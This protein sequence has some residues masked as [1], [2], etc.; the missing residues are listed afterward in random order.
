MGKAPSTVKISKTDFVL[1]ALTLALGLFLSVSFFYGPSMINGADNYIYTDSAHDLLSGNFNAMSGIL[2]ER[3]LLAGGIAFFY[4]LFGYSPASAAAFGVLCFLLTIVLIYLIGRK[5]YS[6]KAG[7]LAAFL[8][9]FLPL[10]VIESS[11]VGDDVPM[12][13]FATLSVFSAVK[14]SLGNSRHS[15]KYFAIAGF[16]SLASFLVSSESVIIM[17]VVL[18]VFLAYLGNIKKAFKQNLGFFLVGLA[19]AAWL[20]LMLSKLGTGNP[21]G[22]IQDASSFYTQ[23]FASY[24][25]SFGSYMTMLFPYNIIERLRLAIEGNFAPLIRMLAVVPAHLTFSGFFGMFG[26]LTAL[27]IVVLAVIPRRRSVIPLFWFAFVLLYLSF[28]TASLEKYVFLITS[29][30]F[31]LLLAPAAV[32]IIS[33]GFTTLVEKLSKRK[34]LKKLIYVLFAFAIA[35]VFINSV[36]I[37]RAMGYAQY[38]YTY[39]L[40][41]VGNFLVAQYEANPNITVYDADLFLTPIDIYYE[42]KTPIYGLPQNCASIGN[43]SIILA[44]SNST[45]VSECNLS[46]IYSPPPQPQWLNDYHALDYIGGGLYAGYALRVYKKK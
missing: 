11:N 20:I 27:F 13:F 40:I 41:N 21:L 2:G 18:F 25:N 42:Y 19:L 24:Q 7:L 28:G 12:A 29:S 6:A 23:G 39:P 35:F 38:K 16:F 45:I 9:S 33:F 10:A 44:Y 36:E 31:L 22:I 32:L 8:Y 1:L 37:I 34:T 14:A 30:R 26:Y 15:G 3:Y 46:M 17:P 43:Q 4:M 5:L